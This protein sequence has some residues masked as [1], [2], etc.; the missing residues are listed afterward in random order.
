MPVYPTKGRWRWTF[1]RIVGGKRFRSTKL[2][3]Q[4]WGRA[5]AE[6]YDRT[7]SSRIYAELS[8]IQKPRLPLSGAVAL[9][10]EHRLPDLK[11]GKK[12]AQDLAHLVDRIENTML[13]D[14][15]KMANEY[16]LEHKHLAPAT[17]RNRLAYL[18]AAVRYAYRKHNYGDRDYSDKM[19]MPTVNNGRQVYAKS[20]Q[21]Q[22]LW[23]AF[24]DPEARAL[25]RLAYYCGTRWRA[26]LLPRQPEDIERN[27]KDVWLNLGTTKN[28]TPRMK[29]VHPE[30]R[31]DLDYLPF[32]KGDNA[33][34]KAFRKARGA[35]GRENLNP[36]DLRHSLASNIVSRGGSLQDVQAALHHDSL[37]SS[38][39]YSH[40]YPERLKQVLRGVGI[41]KNAQSKA[42][43]K[44][45]KAA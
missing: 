1:N 17:V 14:V 36:H 19:T 12:A 35:I 33:F 10:I 18:K 26:E 2:L 38:Q 6:A 3:P 32:T 25:F 39:R 31:A 7:E 24:D 11:N 27:G 43:T 5:Q 13:E 15:A 30:A 29:W 16:E 40:L 34:Y 4:G 23:A 8:G 20:G 21:L 9:Y 28:G 44:K 45:A 42:R 22:S 41:Q 37:I